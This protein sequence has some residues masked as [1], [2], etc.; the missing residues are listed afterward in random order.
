MAFPYLGM[1]KLI[2]FSNYIIKDNFFNFLFDAL[3]WEEDGKMSGW[4]FK[5]S[6][7]Y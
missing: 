7:V 4:C 2:N 5:K 6:K 1:L 3:G